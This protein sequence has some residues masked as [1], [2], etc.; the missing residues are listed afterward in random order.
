MSYIPRHSAPSRHAGLSRLARGAALVLGLPALVTLGAAAPSYAAG[1]SCELSDADT[2]RITAGDGSVMRVAAVEVEGTLF[3]EVKQYSSVVEC[4]GGPIAVSALTDIE[5]TD[6]ELGS[7]YLIDLT[8]EFTRSFDG[9]GNPVPGDTVAFIS[10]QSGEFSVLNV[11]GAQ[12]SVDDTWTALEA[13]GSLALNLDAAAEAPPEVADDAD[14][15][16]VGELREVWIDGGPGNDTLDLSAIDPDALLGVQIQGGSGDDVIDGTP[17]VDAIHPQDGKDTVRTG[18]EADTVSVEPDGDEDTITEGV[19]EDFLQ[20]E[21]LVG[22]RISG[23]GVANDGSG[24]GAEKDNFGDFAFVRGSQGDDTFVPTGTQEDFDGRGDTLTDGDSSTNGPGDRVDYSAIGSAIDVD[25]INSEEH[26]VFVGDQE[27]PA[28][29][30]DALRLVE[31]IIGSALGDT[32]ETDTDDFTFRPGAGKDTV[33]S[34]GARTT[35]VAEA[36]ADGADTF[37]TDD[38]LGE[39][40]YSARTAPISVTLDNLDDDGVPDTIDELGNVTKG[41]GDFIVDAEIAKVTGGSAADKFYGDSSSDQFVGGGGDDYLNGRGG[42]DLLDGGLGADKVFGGSGDDQL[43]GGDGND[44]LDGGVGDDREFGD[45]GDDT[46]LQANGGTA[47]GSDRLVGGSNAD[48]VSYL[49]RSS[50]VTVK[51][52]G[53]YG[54]GAVDE[55]DRVSPDVERAVGTNYNDNLSGGSGANVLLGQGGND[56]LRGNGGND[57]ESGGDGNDTFSQN[58]VAN[59]ADTLFGDAGSD[60]VTYAA[61]TDALITVSKGLTGAGN[62]DGKAGENDNVGVSVEVIIGTKFSDLLLGSAGVD[63][64]V[65]GAGH[66]TVKGGSGNDALYGGTGADVIDGGLGADAMYGEADN[67]RFYAKDGIRDSTINGGPGSDRVRRDSGDPITSIEG[68]F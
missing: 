65:G 60:T 14:V 48:S 61:R 2:L 40:D 64:L 42:G 43:N 68:T 13:P 8:N 58:T 39:W 21:G 22:V 53:T 56:M 51:L 44:S 32:L 47:N 38:G 55:E 37:T 15:T 57:T 45:A 50:G 26:M 10:D 59:G 25:F 62:G 17:A 36:T 1:P 4:T 66:D 54:S 18:A 12:E 3:V 33:I 31:Q 63:K 20:V 9:E 5:L 29:D 16:V 19:E 6:Q 35:L 34:H 41:E 24:L 7:W 49:G 30:I 11:V 67:D 23:D 27:I 28:P 52:D 46:F